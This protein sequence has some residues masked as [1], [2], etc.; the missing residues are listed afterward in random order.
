M[1][2]GTVLQCPTLK[3]ELLIQ[4]VKTMALPSLAQARQSAVRALALAVL[5]GLPFLFIPLAQSQTYQVIHKFAYADGYHPSSTV[6]MDAGGKLYGTTYQGGSADRG[7]VFRLARSGSGWILSTLYMFQGGADGAYPAAGI[8]FGPDGALYGTTSQGG[9]PSCGDCGTVF[10]LQPPASICGSISCP[11]TKT[12]IHLFGGTLQGFDGRVPV[13]DIA[14]DRAGNLYGAASRGG[15]YDDGMVYQLT[16][17]GNNW[18]E[19]VVHSFTNMFG[20]PQAGVTIG[21]NGNL[22][23]T[24]QFAVGANFGAI[25]QL[26]PSGMSWTLEDLYHFQQGG[27]GYPRAG[28]IFDAAGN[29]Y[30]ATTSFGDNGG[31]TAFELSPVNGGWSYSVLYSFVGN[32]GGPDATLTF[33]Q[34]G[35]LY[36]TTGADGAHQLG[37]VFK[38]THNGGAWS[39]ASLYDFQDAGVAAYPQSNVLIDSSGNLYGTFSRGWTPYLCPDGCGGVWEITP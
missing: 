26:A 3:F 33:D 13:G 1:A 6:V 5:V 15:Q 35:N 25:Y 14:F 37:S 21:S 39:Y 16:R 32:N 23:G 29:L 28:M 11:W 18:T 27:G 34:S 17:S 9:D 7:T 19:T 31:G 20:Y 8:I 10:R 12:A 22:Y 4:L 30:G 2:V 38:L 24:V 36:G